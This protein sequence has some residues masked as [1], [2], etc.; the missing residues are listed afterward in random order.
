[1]GIRYTQGTASEE[2]ILYHLNKCNEDF[3]PPLDNK[4]NIQEYATKIFKKSVT[5]EAW[6]D[7]I[8][9]GLVAAYFNDVEVKTGYITNV[10]IISE[11]RGKCI[12]CNLLNKC[13]AYAR[14]NNF[15]CICLEVSAL[16]SHAVLIYKRI[17][18][19]VQEDKDILLIMRYDI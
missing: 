10:S 5:F 4:V 3:I 1:M 14:K 7:D 2:T 19:Q 17:G 11:Y 8:M 6:D 12:A 9:V 18:F 15:K 16:N 13:I